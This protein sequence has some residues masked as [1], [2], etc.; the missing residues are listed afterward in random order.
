MCNFTFFCTTVASFEVIKEATWVRFSTIST[1]S[2]S[3][4]SVWILIL[5]HPRSNLVA[6]LN[7]PCLIAYQ[8]LI[9]SSYR[10]FYRS[11]SNYKGFST[12]ET[13]SRTPSKIST[14]HEMWPIY[15][16]R[17]FRLMHEYTYSLFPS[18]TSSTLHQ[19]ISP[20][21]Y[22]GLRKSSSQNM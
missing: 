7:L 21:V 5:Y 14:G 6:W 22:D 1:L 15:C 2:S 13:L 9:V 3:L 8:C 20:M 12:G 18:V 17:V 16:P 4:K 19:N 11:I 10:K